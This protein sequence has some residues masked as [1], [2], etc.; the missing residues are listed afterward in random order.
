MTRSF[1][2]P[3]PSAQ[4][5]AALPPSSPEDIERMAR[6]AG[7][8]LPPQLMVELCASYPA[9]EAMVRRLPRRRARF[10]EPAHHGVAFDRIDALER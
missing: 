7:L 6:A 5:L 4:T 9:F 10:D 1:V 8:D 3:D 2:R